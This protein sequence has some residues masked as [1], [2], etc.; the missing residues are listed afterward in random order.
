MPGYKKPIRPAVGV[1]VPPHRE[2]PRPIGERIAAVK[3]Q[4]Q[5]KSFL[6]AESAK[7]GKSLSIILSEEKAALQASLDHKLEAHRNFLASGP[8]VQQVRNYVSGKAHGR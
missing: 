6:D 8:T 4:G 2:K 5:N 3:S 7:P 1:Y